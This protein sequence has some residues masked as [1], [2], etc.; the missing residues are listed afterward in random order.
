MK[1]YTRQHPYYCGNDLHTRSLYVCVLDTNAE[2]ILH[3]E[4]KAV[5]EPLLD[6]LAPYIG[7]AVVGVE[8]MH[9]WYWVS[10]FCAKHGIDFIIGHALYMNVPWRQ[11]QER[12][13]RFL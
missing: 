10:D 7:N 9:C 4:I 3:R 2:T 8:C 1:F 11:S 5:P 6:L 13:H 12:S